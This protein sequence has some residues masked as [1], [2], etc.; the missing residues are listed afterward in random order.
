MVTL[1]LTG[2]SCKTSCQYPRINQSQVYCFVIRLMNTSS[3]EY[4]NSSNKHIPE[5]NENQKVLFQLSRTT[6]SVGGLSSLLGFFP[7]I[8]LQ[9]SNWEAFNTSKLLLNL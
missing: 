3:H 5:K 4:K 1:T 6:K 7:V 8:V 9:V 2:R